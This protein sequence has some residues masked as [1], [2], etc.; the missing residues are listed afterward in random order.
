MAAGSANPAAGQ[1]FTPGMDGGGGGA[2]FGEAAGDNTFFESVKTSLPGLG[3]SSCTHILTHA[4]LRF[5]LNM[6][7]MVVML[8]VVGH[9]NIILTCFHSSVD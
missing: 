6:V 3:E 4:V 2:A 7:V 9:F 8:V 5:L 1:T